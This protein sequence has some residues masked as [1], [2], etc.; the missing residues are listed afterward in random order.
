MASRMGSP[1][2]S[3]TASARTCAFESYTLAGSIGWPGAMISSPVEM[4]ATVGFCQTVDLGDS[5]RCQHSGVAARQDLTSAEHGFPARNVG[6][7]ERDSASGRHGPR[8]SQLTTLHVGML[9]HDHGIRPS[10]HHAA[11]RDAHRFAATNHR[12]RNDAG[13]DHLLA[14]AHHSRRLL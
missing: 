3:R 11:G 1:P 4:I 14:E 5:D 9:D 13:V 12:P 6:S 8:D 7:R 10:W 2:S